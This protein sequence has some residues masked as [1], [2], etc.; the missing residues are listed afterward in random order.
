[1]SSSDDEPFIEVRPGD[2]TISDE[3]R[4]QIINVRL[5]EAMK[6]AMR[7][8]RE[9][10][11]AKSTEPVT[12]KWFCGMNLLRCGAVK[13]TALLDEARLRVDV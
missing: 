8:E 6:A 2:V 5:A 12:N 11:A 3:G 4:V 1:M 7:L 13:A 10:A 9:E